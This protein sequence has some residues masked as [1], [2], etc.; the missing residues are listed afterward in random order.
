MVNSDKFFTKH[1]NDI[2]MYERFGIKGKNQ[3]DNFL[4]KLE[5]MLNVDP[6]N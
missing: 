4:N 1:I 3:V 6:S 5:E 2:L